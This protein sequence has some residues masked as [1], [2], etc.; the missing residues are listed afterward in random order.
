MAQYSGA[1]PIQRWLPA[2]TCSEDLGW[3]C[4]P[5]L[6]LRLAGCRSYNQGGRQLGTTCR[7]AGSAGGVRCLSTRRALHHVFHDGGQRTEGAPARRLTH[8]RLA[9]PSHAS[10]H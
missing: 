7:V 4:A 10:S 9:V 5:S 8:G 6:N 2:L 1:T 3:H